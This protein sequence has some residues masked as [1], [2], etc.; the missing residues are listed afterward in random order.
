M[1]SKKALKIVKCC[2]L[3]FNTFV[4][5]FLYSAHTEDFVYALL[6]A[7]AIG[8]NFTISIFLLLTEDVI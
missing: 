3:G 7:S 2:L 4:L 5:A 8:I 6:I 1:G